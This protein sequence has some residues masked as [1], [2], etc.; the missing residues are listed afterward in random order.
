MMLECDLKCL[1]VHFGLRIPP[2]LHVQYFYTG[3]TRDTGDTGDT[4]DTGDP[5]E[6]SSL[7]SSRPAGIIYS[8]PSEDT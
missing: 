1:V 8:A 7:S 4:R 5:G 6:R 2:K 3:D